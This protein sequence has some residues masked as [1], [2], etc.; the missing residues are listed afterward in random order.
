MPTLTEQIAEMRNSLRQIEDESREV[1]VDVAR[2]MVDD[3][4]Y[5]P[6]RPHG[7]HSLYLAA[8]G[9]AP[10]SPRLPRPRQPS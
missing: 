2:T 5:I 7:L 9:R 3:P 6:E 8:V 10:R 1:I 4:V